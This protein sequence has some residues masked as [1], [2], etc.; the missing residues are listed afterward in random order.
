M[1]GVG[2]T[3]QVLSAKELLRQLGNGQRTVKLEPAR[4]GRGKASRGEV[5]AREGDQILGDFSQVAL[6]LTREVLRHT[7]GRV[8]DGC[9]VASKSHRQLRPFGGA[10]QTE[11]WRYSGTI[12]R[13]DP[14]SRPAR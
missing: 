12:L 13:S 8:L 3:R 2:C 5:Q 9:G 11:P 6:E 1:A 14:T 7:L 4:S 10:S